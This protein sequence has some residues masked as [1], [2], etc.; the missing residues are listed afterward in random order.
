MAGLQFVCGGLSDAR[1]RTEKVHTLALLS[2]DGGASI[3]EIH[4]RHALGQWLP[5]EPRNPDEGHSIGD[6]KIGS[7]DSITEMKIAL[8]DAKEIQVHGH[9]LM[10]CTAAQETLDSLNGGRQ[11]DTVDEGASKIQTV[12]VLFGIAG[13]SK[14]LLSRSRELKS[15]C[16]HVR[17]S[18]QA[19]SGS[20]VPDVSRLI[21]GSLRWRLVAQVLRSGLANLRFARARAGAECGADTVPIPESR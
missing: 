5:L 20:Q 18:P 1:C 11:V 21:L 8:R 12:S 9:H 17:A 14:M 6:G 10:W 13:K 2:R 7:I 4:A 16:Y 3:D 19:T 15:L